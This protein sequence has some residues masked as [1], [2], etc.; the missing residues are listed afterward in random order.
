MADK[1]GGA[2]DLVGD[3]LGA[4]KAV[5]EASLA[6]ITDGISLLLVPLTD[7][8]K[9]FTDL[10]AQVQQF[11]TALSPGAMQVFNLALRDLQATIGVALIPII[12]TLTDGLHQAAGL[13]LPAMQKLAPVFAQLAQMFLSIMLPAVQAVSVVFQAL[14]PLLNIA[15]QVWSAFSTAVGALV[16]ILATLAQ[17]ILDTI[18]SAF[19]GDLS[20][21]AAKL[22]EA[23]Y[24][25][26]ALMLKLVAAIATALGLT[27]FVDALL[28]NLNDA[29]HPPSSGAG[30]A[31]Q[32]IGLKG[33]EQIT[34]DLAIA[35]A[36]ATG[37]SADKVG[38]KGILEHVAGLA[39][40]LRK[41]KEQKLSDAIVA[42]FESEAFQNALEAAFKAAIKTVE[43]VG[44]GIGRGI[45]NA[46]IGFDAVPAAPPPNRR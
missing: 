4:G 43:N 1:G 31:A 44:K 13:L 5:V 35:A 17:T 40:D 3:A 38:G 23:I 29:A 42:A 11:V 19:G 21:Y 16:T 45:A 34:K 37:G 9:G 25:V 7:I 28:K 20:D 39:E 33:L 24:Q 8:T 27:G 18:V 41:I 10:A 22:K 26:T 30:G 2:L 46:V 14:V 36:S 12:Q 6:L 32:N 15:L